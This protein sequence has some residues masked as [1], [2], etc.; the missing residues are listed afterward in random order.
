MQYLKTGE[1]ISPKHPKNL[2]KAPAHSRSFSPPPPLPALA[3]LPSL[4]GYYFSEKVN[5]ILAVSRAF[6]DR[7]M[8]GAI[9]AEPDVR[10]RLLERNDEYLVLATDGLWDVM[11]S[12]EACNIVC[13]CAP[14]LGPQAS[15]THTTV[16][17]A[18]YVVD[19]VAVLVRIIMPFSYSWVYGCDRHGETR[20]HPCGREEVS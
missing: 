2:S 13:N 12:Q 6:G 8:K 16:L 20:F 15:Q 10:E 4:P 18:L 11:T 3:A 17:P 1:R 19:G 5:G 14:D 9:N 7:N